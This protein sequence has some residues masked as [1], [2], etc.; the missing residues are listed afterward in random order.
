MGEIGIHFYAN[1]I[2]NR[3][4]RPHLPVPYGLSRLTV[5]SAPKVSISPIQ[6]S[7]PINTAT[8]KK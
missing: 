5:C 2:L 1:I 6:S 4:N 8:L 3:L 7:S